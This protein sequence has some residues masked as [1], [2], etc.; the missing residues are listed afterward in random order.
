MNGNMHGHGHGLRAARR[1]KFLS[2]PLAD[3]RRPF[4]FIAI[5]PGAGTFLKRMAHK[6]ERRIIRHELEKE[7]QEAIKEASVAKPVRLATTTATSDF[8]RGEWMPKRAAYCGAVHATEHHIY[9][10]RRFRVKL[11]RVF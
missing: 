2:K 8:P 4:A 7:I 6:A 10:Q 9:F 3:G 1:E 5:N 11:T